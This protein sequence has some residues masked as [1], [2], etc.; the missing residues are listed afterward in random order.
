MTDGT[1]DVT[2]RGLLAAAAGGA[3]AAA[4]AGPAAAQ[5]GP[6]FGG[7]F[8]DVPNYDGVVDMT[9]EDSVSV[10]VGGEANNGWSFAPAAIQVDP[11][12]EVVWEWTGNGGA[13]NVVAEEG[14]DFSSGTPVTE[15]GTTYSRTFDSEG[16][17]TYYCE[18]HRDVG[19]KAAVVVGEAGG[20]GGSGGGGPPDYGGYL[21]DVPNFESTEDLRGQDQV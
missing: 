5:D 14:G 9:G 4:V 18:P 12:T 15:A 13:H 20:G 16:I 7:W 3:A 1:V 19:M 2:R 8:D 11:G 10:E 21:D 17:V 6:D